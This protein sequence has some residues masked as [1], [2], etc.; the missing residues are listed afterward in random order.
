MKKVFLKALLSLI[1]LC[2]AI[3]LKAEILFEGYYKVSQF[4]KHI[5][6]FVLRNEIDAKTKK[7]KTISY[8]KLGKNGFDMTESLMATSNLD[9]TPAEYT[10]LATD[11]QKSVTID[12]TF[13]GDTMTAMMSES[14]EKRKISKKL[15]KGTFLSSSLYY[16]MLKSKEGLKSGTQFSFNAIAEERADIFKGTSKVD[17]KMQT[18]GALQLLKVQNSFAGSDYE[19]LIT[20]TGQNFSAQT[21][22]TGIETELVKTSEEA[23]QGLKYSTSH[24][25]KIFGTIPEGKINVL[26][27]K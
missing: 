22:A 21:P 1:I 14:G 13:K 8:L 25:E 27:A 6:F 16:M 2:S 3:N 7:F 12:A 18:V 10:Y 4:K 15:Q 17:K 5:G 24:L 20:N 11:G 19:N 9:F 26:N 23:T